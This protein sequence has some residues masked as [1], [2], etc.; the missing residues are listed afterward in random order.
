ML[1]LREGIVEL[2]KKVASSIPS[3]VEDALKKAWEAETD[4]GVRESM[5]KILKQISASRAALRPLCLDTGIPFFFVWVPRG[6]SQLQ[7]REDIIEATRIA[8]RKVPLSPN[9]VDMLSGSNTG[10]NIGLYFPLIHIEE[11]EKNSLTIDLMLQ[12]SEC[13][14]LGS[15]YK[16]PASFAEGGPEASGISVAERDLDGVKRCVLDAVARAKGKGCPP[17]MLG[18]AIGGARDQV[19]YLSRRQLCGRINV[20]NPDTRLAAL[21]ADIKR[22]V[23]EF[24]RTAEGLM[25]NVTAFGVRIAAAHRHPQTCFVDVSFSCWANRKAR[26]I[27]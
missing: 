7:V 21:E 27:W 5:T 8:T 26:L 1:K 13:E 16:L 11:T 12:G 23:N 10:D 25:R 20:S 2:Y 4:A 15:Q 14:N 19:A 22:E 3:D 17:Y 6:L 24:G 9:A 18:V